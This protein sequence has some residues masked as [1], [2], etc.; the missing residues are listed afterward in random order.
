MTLTKKILPLAAILAVALPGGSAM[1]A[2]KAKF[3]F[4]KTS[5]AVAEGDSGVN[6]VTVDVTRAGR[7]GRKALTSAATVHLAIGGTATDGVDYNA[8][9]QG[10]D[11]NLGADTTLSFASGEVTKTVQFDV[12]GDLDIEGVET[13]ALQ[14]K[15]PS[16]NAQVTNPS[17]STVSIVDND[18]PTQ[19]QLD[20]ASYSVSESGGPTLQV[21]VLRSG[22]LT[23]S[24]TAT[25]TETDGTAHNGSD[26][27]MTTPQTVSFASGEWDKVVSI[28]IT[29]DSVKETTESFGLALS[30]PAGTPATTLGAVSAATVSIM[31][32]DAM[33]VFRLDASSYSVGEGDGSLDITIIRDTDPALAGTV[34]PNA[35]S[36]VDWLTT[37][38]TATSADYTGAPASPDNTL[39]FDPGDTS[40]TV[41]VAVLEDALVEGDETFGVALANPVS[42]QLGDPNTATVTI[43]DNDTSTAG[44]TSGAGTGAGGTSTDSSGT[45]TGSTGGEQSVLG[46]R[47][48]G[49]GLSVKAVKKQKLLKQKVLKLTLRSGKSCKVTL[50]TTINQL[51]SKKPARSAKA[52]RFKG[53]QASLTLKPAKAKTVKV[54]FTKKTLAAIKKALRARKNLVATVVV[55]TKDSASKVSRKTLKITIKR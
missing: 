12:V 16:R 35:T 48:A 31:D 23:G 36:S 41:S 9:I 14:L 30:D 42:G 19:V 5:V 53:K 7:G 32:D 25:L 8:S 50:A 27:T 15:A 39:A 29:D 20:S 40:E 4:T 33:P 45:S 17:R 28:P 55:T 1:A 44:D 52:L 26:F 2:P 43:H 6:T 46:A 13:I 37:D 47:Q 54:A 38:G 22:D 11:S 18:G 10:G 34:D 3:R 24:S 51:K 49:C 21:H